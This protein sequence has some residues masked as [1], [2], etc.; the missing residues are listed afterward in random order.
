M[1]FVIIAKEKLGPGGEKIETTEVPGTTLRIG[2]GTDNNLR[3]E[4]HSVQLHH[5]ILLKQDD[6]YI[7]RDLNVLSLTSVDNMP[8]KEMILPETGTIRIGPYS[9]RFTRSAPASPLTIE[10]DVIADAA[11]RVE[12]ATGAL[13]SEPASATAPSTV[14]T[15]ESPRESAEPTISDTRAQIGA[16]LPA[17]AAPGGLPPRPA[18]RMRDEKFHLV[19]AYQ[20]HGPYINKSTITA[21]AVLLVLGGSALVYAFG[22][23]WVFMPGAISIKHRLFANDCARCHMAW[24]TIL[25]GV[26]DKTCLSCHS[27]PPHFNERAFSPAPQC[28]SCHIEHT[29]HAVLAALSVSTCV[30]CHGDLKVKEARVPI[31]TAIH[32]FMVDHPEF[33]ITVAGPEQ[34]TVQRVRLNEGERVRDTAAIKLNHKV[35]MNPDLLG[36]EGPEQL[37]CA[38]CHRA[39]PQGAYMRA[40]NYE[41][42]CMRCHRLDFDE[43]LPGKAVPHGQSP[44]EM[45]RFLRATYAEYYLLQHQSELK[46]QG[47]ARRL[48]GAP[49]SKE[50]MWVNAIIEDA[51]RLLLGPPGTPTKKGKCV[52]CHVLDRSAESSGPAQVRTA[53]SAPDVSESRTFPEIMKTAMPKH[54]FPY[55]VFDHKAHNIVKCVACHEAAPHSERTADVLLPGIGSCRNCHF[56]PGGARTQ[57]LTCHVYHDKSQA[58]KPEGQPYSIEQIKKGRASPLSVPANL[59]SP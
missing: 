41:K 3:L 2:R 42:D 10:Y 53:K 43:R 51:E 14:V 7:L 38:S 24:N 6:R 11:R 27:G 57:C 12:L 44:E 13:L 15:P 34:H 49:R 20:L 52:L 17:T 45:G 36:P 32:S 9:L 8:V 35:H 59:S 1:P 58:Q 5:A 31:A 29:G 21:L 46:T 39:E 28:A 25:T 26:P 33:A 22:K 55:S 18:L 48:P 19:A 23:H 4:D 50:E 56:E 47:P 37:T 40:V 30:Q 54:W 16:P